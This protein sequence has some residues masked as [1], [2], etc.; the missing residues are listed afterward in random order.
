MLG[1]RK[2]G[3]LEGDSRPQIG[4]AKRAN[5]W[6]KGKREELLNAILLAL[7]LVVPP[8]GAHGALEL[9]ELL[10]SLLI[11]DGGLVVV[12]LTVRLLGGCHVRVC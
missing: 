1:V 4:Y 8:L 5:V 11:V 9:S 2:C 6:R 10:V 3:V 12:K 7:L